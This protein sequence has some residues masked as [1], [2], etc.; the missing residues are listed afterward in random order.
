MYL[1]DTDVIIWILRSKQDI[2]EKISQIKEQSPVS[3]SVMSIAE[4]YKNIFPTELVTTE[5]FLNQ[6]IVY[7]IDSKIAKVA[8]LYWQQYNKQLKGLSISDCLI[9]GTANINDLTVVSLNIKHFP[10]KDIKVL[11]PS[12]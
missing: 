2:I 10:M 3:I 8:G 12:S 4:V 11:D 5:E 9:A 6:H 1:L 7:N